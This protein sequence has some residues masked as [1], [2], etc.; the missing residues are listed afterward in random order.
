M[1]TRKPKATATYSQVTVTWPT[2]TTTY[3][4]ET[5]S[6]IDDRSTEF[7][8]SGRRQGEATDG[9]IWIPK[10]SVRDLKLE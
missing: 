5:G 8:F 3:L 4:L 10:S 9:L 7:K 1:P 6:G 2:G